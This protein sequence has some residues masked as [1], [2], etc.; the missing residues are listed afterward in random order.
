M[1]HEQNY[2]THDLELAVIIFTLK[3]WRHYLYSQSC[4]IYTNH[5]SLKYIY[6][7]WELNLRQRRWLEL[8]KDYDCNI[9]Y[10]SGKA[11]VVVD[12]LSRKSM[13]SLSHVLVH[14]RPLVKEVRDCLNDGVMLS[15]SEVGEMMPM[16][17]YDHHWWKRYNG[18]NMTVNSI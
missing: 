14:Q 16:C 10:H 9:L 17:K 8:F 4:E 2:L 6:D 18:C 12:A 5:K 1:K 3:I 13:G 15:I 7:Q 11:N